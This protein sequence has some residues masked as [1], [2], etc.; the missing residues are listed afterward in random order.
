LHGDYWL[1]NVLWQVGQLAATID[2]EDAALGDPL[3]DLANARLELFWGCGSKA[4]LDFTGHYRA[5]TAVDCK[6]LP[7][8]DLWV[9][10]RAAPKIS[11]WGLE[12]SLEL[13]MQESLRLFA[14]QAA[15]RINQP[16][17]TC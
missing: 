3:A 8:W 9:A 14:D 1:G 13:K 6:N 4:M 2:W 15:G 17:R 10:L 12:T 16:D 7:W 11:G 5:L